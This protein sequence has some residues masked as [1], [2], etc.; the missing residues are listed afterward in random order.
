MARLNARL[1]TL[2]R[3]TGGADRPPRV[4]TV[5][6]HPGRPMPPHPPADT[7]LIM[8]CNGRA[9]CSICDGGAA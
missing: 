6:Y 1:D 8:P 3:R 5:I 4:V 7:I 2:E 9:P